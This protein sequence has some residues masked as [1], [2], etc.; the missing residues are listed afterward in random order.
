LDASA[1]TNSTAGSAMDV[2]D[3]SLCFS[4]I[5][6]G[7]WTLDLMMAK[8]STVTRDEILN[9]L[10]K[11]IWTYQRAKVMVSNDVLLLRYVWREA[12][13][14]SKPKRNTYDFHGPWF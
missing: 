14:V 7:D 5:F 9:A 2:L 6:R 8:L 13:K 12:D 1:I 11:I 3:P 4:I 10:D